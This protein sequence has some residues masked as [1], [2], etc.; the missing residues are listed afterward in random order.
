MK[1]QALF[2]A[3]RALAKGTRDTTPETD[4]E[5]LARVALKYFG[6]GAAAILRRAAELADEEANR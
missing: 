6:D 1:Q 5:A 3:E 4:A 2:A